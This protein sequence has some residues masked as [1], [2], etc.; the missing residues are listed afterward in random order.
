MTSPQ[1]ETLRAILTSLH[2]A[3]KSAWID[4]AP[5]TYDGVSGQTVNSN[6]PAGPVN[7]SCVLQ[8]RSAHLGRAMISKYLHALIKQNSRR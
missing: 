4:Q 5:G 3:G 6:R 2:K 8:C 1:N 7:S